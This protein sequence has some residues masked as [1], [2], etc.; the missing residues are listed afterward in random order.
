MKFT[1]RRIEELACPPGSKDVL[2][3]DGHLGVRVTAASQTGSLAG[4]FYLAQYSAAGAKK[5]VPLGSCDAISLAA[6]REATKALMGDVA[7][8][9]DPAAA[10]KKAAQEAR[11]KAA[12][13]ALTLGA[14]IEQWEALGLADRR[15][16]YQTETVRALRYAF[17]DH[18]KTPAAELG[19]AIVVHKLDSL[20]KAGKTA[21][22]SRTAAYGRACYQWAIKRGSL[23]TNPFHAL[24]LAAV[25]KRERV[26]TDDELRA[27]WRGTERPGSFN[28]IVRMLILTGQRREEVG[29]MRWDELDADPSTWVIPRARAKKAAGHLVPVSREAQA[30]LSAHRR[31]EEADFVFPGERGVFSGWS[32]AKA[33]LDHESAVI[34]WRLHDLRRTMATGLQRLGVRLEVTEAVLGHVSGSRGGIIGVYQRHDW[35]DEKRAALAAWG[36]HV[37]SIVEGRESQANVTPLRARAGAL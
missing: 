15:P 26:L 12:H 37:A 2:K 11:R 14:L 9:R 6:A 28:S 32:K 4:K 27:I 8:G 30:L 16:R 36:A 22:A 29:A 33:A 34:D 21:M 31:H 1:Q 20:S 10:R 35:A 19:R 3:F 5:R 13:D 17:A 23:S 18:L 24:P 7:K 25:V